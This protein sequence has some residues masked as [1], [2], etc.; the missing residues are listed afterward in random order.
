MDRVRGY[1][2][3]NDSYVPARTKLSIESKP[4]DI[5]LQ[6]WKIRFSPERNFRVD[7]HGEGKIRLRKEAQKL[8]TQSRLAGRVMQSGHSI[9]YHV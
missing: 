4:L 2:S 1:S 5:V 7:V 9:H 8:K 6:P 3:V